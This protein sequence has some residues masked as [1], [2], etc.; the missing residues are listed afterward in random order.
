MVDSGAVAWVRMP[1]VYAAARVLGCDATL[2]RMLQAAATACV[3]IALSA[4]WHRRAPLA[5]R[6]SALALG[7]PL[8]S[9]YAFDCDLVV[10]VLPLAWL[11]R[12]ALRE[13]V[14]LGQEALL[15]VAWAS[16]ALFWVIAMAGGPPL[17]PAVLATLMVLVWR[18]VFVPA[19]APLRH[20]LGNAA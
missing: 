10:L 20:A 4:I 19:P 9:P 2:A 15:A 18:R 13:K 8:A 1:T 12:D 6:G 14:P 17:M 3:V 7:L 16:P 11:F 5:W